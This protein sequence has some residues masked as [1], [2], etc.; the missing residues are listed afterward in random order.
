MKRRICWPNPDKICLQGG[1][2]YCDD[3]PFKG[4][5]AIRS[6]AYSKGWQADFQYGWENGADRWR[7]S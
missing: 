5:V 2:I 7:P 6:Y 4:E 3:H 1:C